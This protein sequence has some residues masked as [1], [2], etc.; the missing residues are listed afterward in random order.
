MRL[1]IKGYPTLNSGLT[2]GWTRDYAAAPNANRNVSSNIRLQVHGMNVPSGQYYR[3][4]PVR[5]KLVWTAN[6]W[7]WS[8]NLLL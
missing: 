5:E 1:I 2:T 7:N 4:V 3:R 8:A 6:G